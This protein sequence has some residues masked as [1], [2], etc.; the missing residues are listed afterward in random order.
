MKI[1]HTD[2]R[3]TSAINGARVR[4]ASDYYISPRP[5]QARIQAIKDQVL[6]PNA[7]TTTTCMQGMSNIK[8]H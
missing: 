3:V 2:R 7:I 6:L 4:D 1:M 8:I 5:I